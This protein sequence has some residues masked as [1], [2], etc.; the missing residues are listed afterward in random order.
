MSLPSR[1]NPYSFAEWLQARRVN[2]FSVAEFL[3]RCARH[4]LGDEYE[5]MARIMEPFAMREITVVKKIPI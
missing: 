3:Q 1:N 5:E 2:F 4:Y